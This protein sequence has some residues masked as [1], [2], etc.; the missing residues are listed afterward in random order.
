MLFADVKQDFVYYLEHERGLTKQSLRT[1]R[2]WLLYFDRF[3]E[4]VSTG[5][6]LEDRLSVPLLRRY[7]Y[8]MSGKGLRPRS[9]R[10]AFSPLRALGE[11]CIDNGLLTTNPALALKLPKK[12]AAQRLL[13][14]AAEL[15]ALLAAVERQ[16]EPRR[17][18]LSRAI[19]STL[20]FC[21]VRFSELMDIKVGHV[22]VTERTLLI[23]SG[24]GN[25]SR[26]LYPPPECLN[27]LSEWL[28]VRA[29]MGC[30]HDWLFAYDRNRRIGEIG[31]REMLEDV[32][33]IA[34]L[35]GH[36]N[37]KPH[38][39][40]HAFATRL[41]K[42]G[43]DIKSIQS[44]LGHSEATT[45]LIYLHASE[46]PAQVMAELASLK[47]KEAPAGEG[48]GSM[49]PAGKSGESGRG[50]AADNWRRRRRPV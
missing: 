28:A 39:I 32:K 36:D 13:V 38:S 22:S 27:A 11:F 31:V 48:A 25:K 37:I 33:A 34:G 10:G 4:S 3:C 46:Q 26:L 14:S 8:W 44:A 1:Y 24:K 2:S 16:R 49:P 42:N 29:K 7:L 40:R 50:T 9:V 17:L 18:A 45:T 30:K 15:Q 6:L 47:P 21:G 5:P 19:L 12:D 43:A 41:M 20:I 23:A 35:Q